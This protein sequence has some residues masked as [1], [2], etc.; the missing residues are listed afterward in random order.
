MP[1]SVDDGVAKLMELL[2]E[3]PRKPAVVVSG[4]FGEPPALKMQD[5]ELPL[6]RFL[7]KKRVYYPGV[8][9][10]VDADLS[11]QTDPYLDDHVVHKERLLP[12]VLGLEAMAQAAMALLETDRVPSFE[13]VKLSHP[14][15]ITGNRA[16]TIRLA[17][18]RRGTDLV[19]VCLRSEGTDFGVD[20]FRVLCRF[21]LDQTSSAVAGRA[22]SRAGP[23]LLPAPLLKLDPASDLYGRI[24]FHEGRFQRVN[25]YRF[26]KATEC[27]AEIKPDGTTKWF[28][29]YVP[30]YFVL[31]DPGARD[32][33][34]HA[35]QA[36]I[37]HLRILPLSIDTLTIFDIAP[38][39]R[40]VRARE[41]A[42]DPNTFTY[43]LEVAD[44]HG[45]MVERW[46]GLKLRAIE[47]MPANAPWPVALAGPWLERRLQELL[48]KNSLHVALE[49]NG[50][51]KRP[52]LTSANETHSETTL[53]FRN[54]GAHSSPSDAAMQQALGARIPIWRR[55]DGKPMTGRGREISASHHEA[56]TLA[57]AGDRRVACDVEAVRTRPQSVWR[58]LLGQNGYAMAEKIARER[59]ETPASTASRMWT[60]L[61]CLKKAGAPVESPIVLE[62]GAEDGW[63]VFRSGDLAVVSCLLAM[64]GHEAEMAVAFAV[65]DSHAST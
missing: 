53:L 43:D 30:E 6:R 4:R 7:E 18:L 28:G 12:A 19:E 54:G 50:N 17:A 48:A 59:S 57:I 49:Q 36:C 5:P 56:L 52:H 15:A 16:T 47:A 33:A 25:G 58:D 42:R 34:L 8:E 9:L 46:T 10:V 20:H 22:S 55:P 51:G 32:A 3:R 1:V 13:H 11:L 14:V 24:L 35:V 63:V 45:R 23:A 39:A 64:Q 21:N 41:T 31:G 40:V 37:P 44:E 60:V 27:I 38:G 26:L 2:R 61:E 29:P 62:S 65:S